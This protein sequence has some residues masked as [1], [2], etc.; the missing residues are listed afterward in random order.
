V[1]L[2]VSDAAILTHLPQFLEHALQLD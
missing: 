1:S 2:V